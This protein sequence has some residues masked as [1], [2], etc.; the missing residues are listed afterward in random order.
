MATTSLRT[1]QPSPP[2]RSG[3]PPC[4]VKRRASSSP[5][6]PWGTSSRSWP[7]CHAAARSSPPPKATFRTMRRPITPSSPELDFALSERTPTV[8]CRSRMFLKRFRM[9]A[10]CTAQ[11]RHLSSSRTVTP[12]PAVDRSLRRT[13][14]SC[15]RRLSHTAFRSTSMVR[16][17]SM[18]LS[19]LASRH[20]SWSR[21]PTVQPSA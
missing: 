11:S 3:L 17:S 15:A 16:A 2:S 9:P 4:S 21:M 14:A 8:R 13:C 1:I 7:T 12:T 18:R 19:G 6:A 20:V 10:T 5:Q